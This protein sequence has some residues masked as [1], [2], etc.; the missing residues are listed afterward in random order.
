MGDNL[1]SM[2]CMHYLLCVII[3]TQWWNT[4][5][6]PCYIYTSQWID[7][8]YAPCYIYTPFVGYY[9]CTCYNYTP[10]L[11]DIYAHVIIYTPH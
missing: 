8:I 3:Y 9:L 4:I 10:M 7:D 2:V 1:Y 5:Y 6:M 11:D